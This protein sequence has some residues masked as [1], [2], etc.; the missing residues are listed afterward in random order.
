VAIWGYVRGVMMVAMMLPPKA[1]RV[2]SK[3]R[4]SGSM[5]K[6]VQSAVRP[7]FKAAATWGIKARPR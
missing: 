3:R 1:G 2:W 5:A 7:V 4:F 6:A